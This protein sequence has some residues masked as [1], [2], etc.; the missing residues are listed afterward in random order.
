L[1]FRLPLKVVFPLI[2][3]IVGMFIIFITVQY[4][5]HHINREIKASQCQTIRQQSVEF[6]S[7]L[8]ILIRKHD[9]NSIQ[10]IVSALN[11]RDRLNFAL[12][13]NDNGIVI[14]SSKLGYVSRDISTI[15]S[16]DLKILKE[17][18]SSLQ[19]EVIVS[20]SEIYAIYPLIFGTTKGGVIPDKVGF[21]YLEYDLEKLLNSAKKDELYHTANILLFYGFILM[22]FM[23]IIYFIFMERIKKLIDITNRFSK[24]DFSKKFENIGKD[25][26]SPLMINLNQM[27]EELIRSQ[28]ELKDL[29][30]NLKAQIEFELRKNQAKEQ[31][32]FQ[33]SRQVAMGELLVNIAHQWR[34]PLNNIGAIIQ[35][36]EDSFN[37]GDISKESLKEDVISIMGE[38]RYLSE[39]I[40]RFS[41]YYQSSSDK[42]EF[43]TL[44]KAIFEAYNMLAPTLLVNN[45]HTRVTVED[46]ILIFGDRVEFVQVFLNLFSN[47][48]DLAIELKKPLN[49][50]IFAKYNRV[51]NI[52]SIH[53]ADNGGGIKKDNLSKIFDPYFTTKDKSKGVGLGLFIAKSIIE[54]K[55]RGKIRVSNIENG[56]EF[57][58]EVEHARY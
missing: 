23:T 10:Q 32:M 40:N 4:N 29:N 15:K 46:K 3:V 8:N 53:F 30:D 41:N 5:L 17:I 54:H 34:Q 19:G 24:S 25:E 27:A 57:I 14:A 9:F 1:I 52:I 55:F 11:S 31:L 43:F 22:I 13:I 35:N 21:L 47:V 49:I 12:V 20:K 44:K 58:I 28:N 6:Q 2:I 51:D 37:Y 39:T 36:L 26:L 7:I 42:E 56:A 38:L 18:K 16:L 48:K 45:I 33:K 50:E